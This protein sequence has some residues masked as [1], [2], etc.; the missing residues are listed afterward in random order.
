METKKGKDGNKVLEELLREKPE[1]FMGA[2]VRRMF[3]GYDL[4]QWAKA[5]P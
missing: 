3:L 4:L 2:P 5:A 1:L